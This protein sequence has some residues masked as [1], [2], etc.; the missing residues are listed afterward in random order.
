MFRAE[1]PTIDTR[2]LSFFGGGVNGF[3]RAV[4]RVAGWGW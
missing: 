1:P 4:G 2:S 3:S